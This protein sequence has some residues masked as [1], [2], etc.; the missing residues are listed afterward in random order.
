MKLREFKYKRSY[1]R[2]IDNPL[3]DFLI[4]VLSLSDKFY[5][6]TGYFSSKMLAL[7]S[8]GIKDFIIKNDG[9]IKLIVGS[10]LK[11]DIEIINLSEIELV[12]KYIEVTEPQFFSKEIE[13]NS[14]SIESLK[15]LAWLL[16][17]R[18]IEIKWAIP[19][20]SLKKTHSTHAILHE[21]IGILFDSTLNDYITFSG[22]FNATYYAWL[23]NREEMKIFQSWMENTKAYAEDDLKKFNNYWSN[24]DRGLKVLD[25][26]LKLKK[27]I[28]E[29]YLPKNNNVN[30]IDFEYIDEYAKEQLRMLASW[31]I[32]EELQENDD[33]IYREGCIVRNIE[34]ISPYSH[35]DKALNFLEQNNYKGFL[36]MATGSGKTK[37]SILGGYRLYKKL[38]DNNFPLIT[39]ILVPDSYLVD[40][41]YIELKNYSKNVIKCYSENRNWREE[42]KIKINR[43]R[44]D[45]IDHC[46]IISTIASL[47]YNIWEKFILKPLEK[48]STKILLI[49]D[50]AHTLGA[51][52]GQ[53]L[54]NKLDHYFNENYKIGLSATP[55]RKYDEKGTKLVLRWFSGNNEP[56]IFEFSLKQAQL[57]NMLTKFNYFPIISQISQDEFNEFEE[58]TKKIGKKM[59]L[60]MNNEEIAE[61]LTVLLNLRANILK[62]CLDKLNKFQT[63]IRKLL[64]NFSINEKINLSKLVVFC[65]DHE[66]VEAVKNEIIDQNKNLPLNNQINYH[67]IDGNDPNE[68]RMKRIFDLTHEKVNLLIVMKCLDRGVDIP[69]LKKA[70][71]LSSS[72]TELEHIQR[73]G[74]L[75]R[76]DKSKI[77]PVEIYDI[78]VI[79]SEK[80]IEHYFDISKKIYD[81][82]RKRIEFFMEI[83]ENK[84]E[85]QEFIWN[86][87]LKF[88]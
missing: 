72:G 41:W 70:I 33:W 83:A 53:Y 31:A 17:N 77:S 20:E 68:V 47:K 29:K 30:K 39:I 82:E 86:L 3:E 4:P 61:E 40:Q 87:D 6:I 81:I 12:E 56:N 21:K 54:L 75:L 64:T 28:I 60:L 2:G 46:Y 57:N 22:S 74:R 8:Y 63:L 67:T 88:F 78:I 27:K 16:Y 71:F 5:Y 44:M 65:K 13:K 38:L 10:F 1:T 26:P 15:L 35:Q 84:E 48:S 25:F 24:L 37:T 9:V 32:Y 66:Q 58:F 59:H 11:P 7:L 55:I 50:E 45:S 51:P 43:L 23:L 79:P 19:L 42:L 85:I 36:Q 18:R 76:L 49:G 62:K 69:S 14:K 73:T 52:T 80:Q 34:R